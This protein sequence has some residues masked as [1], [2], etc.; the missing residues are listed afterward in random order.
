[1]DGW[2]NEWERVFLNLSTIDGLFSLIC[3]FSSRY[4]LGLLL[5]WNKAKVFFFLHVIDG[6]DVLFVER[7]CNEHLRVIL[8]VDGNTDKVR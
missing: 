5:E 8:S 7:V 6:V 3:L 4:L 2:M 1:M